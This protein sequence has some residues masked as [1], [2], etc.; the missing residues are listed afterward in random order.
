VEVG[1][2]QH[3][4]AFTDAMSTVAVELATFRVGVDRHLKFLASTVGFE[5][6]DH[7]GAP[8]LADHCRGFLGD[9]DLHVWL[10]PLS[11][12]KIPSCNRANTCS[13]LGE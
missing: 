11:E 13:I 3:L 12:A 6:I 9:V 7:S 8:T 2:D 10:N 4:Q 1:I 5:E